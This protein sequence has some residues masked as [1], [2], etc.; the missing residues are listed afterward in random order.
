MSTGPEA[1]FTFLPI[2]LPSLPSSL[3]GTYAG[4]GMEP[5][6]PFVAGCPVR[7]LLSV[8]RDLEVPHA[9]RDYSV[10]PAELGKG[11]LSS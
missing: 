11:K 4:A 6:G 7:I 8:R 9:L 10:Q 3:E 5:P 2:F 1:S